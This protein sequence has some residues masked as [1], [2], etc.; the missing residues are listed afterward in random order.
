MNPDQYQAF[1]RWRAK[2]LLDPTTSYEGYLHYLEA[3]AALEEKLA[4]EIAE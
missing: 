1:E 4:K 2:Q 3:E